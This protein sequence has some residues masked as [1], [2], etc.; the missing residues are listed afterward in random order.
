MSCPEC[1]SGHKHT[2]DP[3]GREEKIHGLDTYIAEPKD[4]KDAKGIIIIIPDAFGW[5]FVNNRILADHYAAAGDFLVY[6][7]DFMEGSAAPEWLLVYVESVADTS[8]LSA[9]LTKP[10]AIAMLLYGAGPFMVRNRFGI[11]YPTVQTFFQKISENEGSKLPVGA[12]GFCWGGRHAIYLSHGEKS[13]SGKPLVNASFTGH[14]SNCSFPAE[15]Q[16]VKQPLSIALGDLDINLGPKQVKVIEDTFKTLENVDT[17]IIMY[18]GAGHGFCIR[19]DPGREVIK[20]A[21]AAEKQAI[22]FFKK[23]FA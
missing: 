14:P 2:S 20:Q 3:Q 12:A 13:S 21:E 11:S 1:F 15:L 23:H 17:E 19:A 22:D 10:Y 9:W 16:P 4:G 18:P 6:L 5:Q 7:P 8:S